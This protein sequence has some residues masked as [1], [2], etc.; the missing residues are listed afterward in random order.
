MDFWSSVRQRD[1]FEA[2]LEVRPRVVHFSGHGSTKGA[3]LLENDAGYGRSVPPEALAD[4]FAAVQGNVECVVLNACYSEVQAKAIASHV[5]FVIGTTAQIADTAAVT[6]SIGFYQALG[7]GCTFRQA[8][9]VGSA[10]V[11]ASGE[12]HP[13]VLLERD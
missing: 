7:A 8:F 2:L 5:P 3:I 6:F 12:T 11:R 10:S 4:L 13:L 1:L 9:D